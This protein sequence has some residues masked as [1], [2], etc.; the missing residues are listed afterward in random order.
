MYLNYVT[1][2]TKYDAITT[3]KFKIQPN[4]RYH[5]KK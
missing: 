5:I 3:E 4:Y 1:L 2:S